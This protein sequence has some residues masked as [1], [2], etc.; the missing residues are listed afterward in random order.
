[1]AVLTYSHG[2]EATYRSK[3]ESKYSNGEGQGKFTSSKSGLES[4]CTRRLFLSFVLIPR[5]TFNLENVH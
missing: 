4:A 3:I 1:M 5:V 2:Y